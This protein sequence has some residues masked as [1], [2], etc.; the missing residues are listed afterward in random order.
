MSRGGYTQSDGTVRPKLDQ[1]VKNW[2]TPNCPDGGRKIPDNAIIPT[3]ATAYY[4]N[5]KK[6]QLDLNNAVRLWPPPNVPNRGPEYSKSHRPESGGIDLQSSVGLPDRA[7]SSTNGRSRG[8]W[9]TPQGQE[10]GIK[11][12]R[13]VGRD[14]GR[15][16]DKETG[17]LAQYA[18]TQQ[19]KGKLN[20]DWVE[21]LMGLEV[22]WTAFD[23]SATEFHPTRRK[24]R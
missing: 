17:R 1:Q 13:L 20:P 24:K 19:V 12:D 21:Q 16:Y 9:R 22:G 7:S 14:G 23:F 8:L 11:A 4:P 6:V 5:G 15:K 2:P 10:P 3:G 18:L